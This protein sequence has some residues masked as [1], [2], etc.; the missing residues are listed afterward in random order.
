[1][2]KQLIDY[3]KKYNIAA[4]RYTS[5]PTVPHWDTASWT[6]GA[7]ISAVQSAALESAG[8]VSL[9][10]HLPYCERLCTYCGC[11]TRITKNHR[12]ELPYI[13]SV[14]SEWRLY[15]EKLNIKPKIVDLHLGGGTPTFFSPE[16]LDYLIKSILQEASVGE[17]T[18]FSFEA[19]PANTTREHLEVLFALGFRR[20]SLGIQDFDSE[21]QRIINRKQSPDDVIRVMQEARHI[22]YTSI[23]FDLIYGLPKQTL[24]GI[25]DTIQ[26]AIAMHPDRI[27][28]YSYAHVPWIKPGQRLYT[29]NDLPS[30]E[31]KLAFYYAGKEMII[32]AGYLDIGMDHFAFPTDSLA[33]AATEGKL[34]RNFMGYTD[35]KP[36]LLLG[37]GVSSIS[38]AGAAYAQNVKSV[39]EYRA[40][41]S[42]GEF[43]LFKGHIQTASDI[44]VKKQILHI[45]CDGKL[46]LSEFQLPTEVLKRLEPLIADG[47]VLL[48]PH[49]LRVTALGRSFLRIICMA[50]DERYHANEVDR[51]LFSKAV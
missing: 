45:M 6:T 20:L 47:F 51:P 17:D 26:Q 46:P 30:D 15:L 14:I 42:K 49:R 41:L 29:E 44:D 11:N 43:P 21:V 10:I 18:T 23:N 5:Y 37:L 19:H 22:G 32:N 24:G 31:A 28:F 27:A 3:I 39:E 7:W 48:E 1:M 13:E 25:R 9:Y 50:F 4:P 12:V 34:H 33:L 16:N 2:E 40:L 36:S 8:E 38:D 35:I